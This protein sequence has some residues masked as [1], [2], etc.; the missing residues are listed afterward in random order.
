MGRE[1]GPRRTNPGFRRSATAL[2]AGP[3][4]P[5]AGERMV[6]LSGLLRLGLPPSMSGAAAPL[7]TSTASVRGG[8]L[9][10]PCSRSS[11]SRLLR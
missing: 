10:E 3:I 9:G 11:S 8:G 2:L 5:A 7:A 1:T 6:G 4:G